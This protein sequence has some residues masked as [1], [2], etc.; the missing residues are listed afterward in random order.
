MN[1]TI[2]SAL[3]PN[4]QAAARESIAETLL[5]FHE[6]ALRFAVDGG[7]KVH[8]LEPHQTY[9]SASR[10][11]AKLHIDVD[12]WS[13]PPSGLFVVAEK[14]VYL[15]SLSPMTVSHEFGH[16]LDCILGG[17][18]YRSGIHPEIRAAFAPARSFI[19]PYAASGLDEYFAESTRA[20]VDS[21]NDP[22]SAWPE[23][24]CERL[25]KLDPAMFAIIEHIFAIFSS[26]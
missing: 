20:Y 13:S 23:A 25:R 1:S 18:V 8:V 16:A 2:F 9:A 10:E 12:A 19:T 26:G 4:A 6:G 17:G 14:T 15:S 5:K 11:L 21:C 7:V 24:T 3:V 22:A